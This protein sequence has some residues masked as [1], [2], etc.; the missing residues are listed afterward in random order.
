MHANFQTCPSLGVTDGGNQGHRWKLLLRWGRGRTGDAQE[1]GRKSRH[2]L[3]L[4]QSRM[5]FINIM[6]RKKR[7]ARRCSRRSKSAALLLSPGCPP[8]VMA[9]HSTSLGSNSLTV[10]LMTAV[11]VLNH[12]LQ[13]RF[14]G[15]PKSW[16]SPPYPVHREQGTKALLKSEQRSPGEQDRAQGPGGANLATI[17]VIL[18]GRKG[19][20][21]GSDKLGKGGFKRSEQGRDKNEIRASSQKYKRTG[22]PTVKGPLRALRGSLRQGLD[23]SDH[24]VHILSVTQNQYSMWVSNLSPPF[25]NTIFRQ[26]AP[27]LQNWATLGFEMPHLG[28]IFHL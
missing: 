13:L 1:D 23:Q 3:V 27:S 9:S 5:L 24:T 15:L 21:P 8:S 19:W 18:V 25:R 22:S 17:A 26:P 28:K 2:L 4:H 6:L 7:H 12:G 11:D 14:P 16:K 10:Q 20:E